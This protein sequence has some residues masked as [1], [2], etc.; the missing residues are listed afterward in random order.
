MP[1]GVSNPVIGYFG[2]CAVK[3][4]DYSLAARFISQS[5]GLTD[6]NVRA[7]IDGGGGFDGVVATRNV[8]V[9]NCE[10]IRWL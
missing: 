3:F 7:Q 5:Y 6:R 10:G 8:M 2:F 9:R 1:A 4:A